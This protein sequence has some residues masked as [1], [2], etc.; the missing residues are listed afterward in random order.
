MNII[1]SLFGKSLTPQERLRR[2]QR[3][4]EK[5]QREL[6]RERGK[7]EGQES[8][9]ISDIKKSAKNGQMA[10]TKLMAKDL[11]RTRKYIQKFYQMRTQLQ[12][13]SL[14]IQTLRS[15]QQMSEAMKGATKSMAM[16]NRSLNLPQITRIMNDFER[17]SSS[18]DMKEEIMSDAVDDVMEDDQGEEE[19]EKIVG[20]VLDDIGVTLN[21]QLANTPDTLDV[22]TGADKNKKTPMAEG[23][24]GSAG[25]GAGAGAANP[26]TTT[27]AT[28]STQ[29]KTDEDSL[30]ARLDRLRK[31]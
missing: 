30:Q 24:S 13:V 8:K 22:D 14:R 4:L 15:N 26:T 3:A 21:Q 5:A 31:D 12:A 16:M 7:L 10:P 17:E 9:L 29:T 27:Q 1:E 11:V 28:T 25:A 2:H 19:E 6:D 20:Q 23:L 18:M